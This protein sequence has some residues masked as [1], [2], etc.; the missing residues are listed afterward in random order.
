MASP[1]DDL[2]DKFN[3]AAN[4]IQSNHSK[5]SKPDLLIF[6]A[7]YKQGTL[8]KC[9]VPKPGIFRLQ[10]RAKWD[11]WNKI[12]DLD[13]DT[14]KTSYI[15]H[16]TKL[17]PD[18]DKNSDPKYSSTF[19]NS[20]SRPQFL[21]AEI[22]DSE[23]SIQDFIKEENMEKLVESLK[24]LKELN[25]LDENGLGLIH[26]AADHGNSEILEIILKQKNININ[27]KDSDGQT[28]LLYASSCEHSDCVKL[29]LKYN[30][31]K[32]IL[33]DEGNS[34]LDVTSCPEIKQ[35]LQ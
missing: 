35:I 14:A 22:L 6:Y 16:L 3:L 28:A 26:W 4:Y 17:Q 12:Q 9:D 2:D 13:L 11:A 31:D 1:L 32:E 7:N 33:D 5:F 20:V 25:C 27:L 30:A 18:W 21:D 29:L 8:G 15:Q 10:E 34:C 19:G 24:D 23:K